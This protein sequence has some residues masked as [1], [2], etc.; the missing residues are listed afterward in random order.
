[1]Q[2]NGPAPAVISLGMYQK[3]ECVGAFRYLEDMIGVVEGGGAED[4]SRARVRCAWAK[5]RELAPVLTSLEA[6]LWVKGKI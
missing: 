5:F 6:S 3:L 1:V 2:S 4:A